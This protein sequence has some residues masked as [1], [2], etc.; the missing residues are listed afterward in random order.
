M[1]QTNTQPNQTNIQ[2][3]NG[4]LPNIAS[5][6]YIHAS[7]IVIGHVN[8]GENVSV[9]PG[10]VIRGD[11]NFIKI[12]AGSNIQDCSVLHVNHQSVQDPAGSPLII[13]NNVTIGHSVILH[14]CTIEDESL[15]GMGSIVMDK[16]IVQKNVLIAAG[17]LVPE[18]KVLESGYLY[19]GSPV[20]KVRA[21]TLDEIAFLMV[22]AQ[23]YMQLKDAYLSELP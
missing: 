15:I 23:N 17:S 14:G 16:A 1:P 22:S 8:L 7:A 9:W 13:G 3:F 11:I 20:K 4:H 21:L 2:R 5:G 10:V 18:G 12:G 19:M 6:V